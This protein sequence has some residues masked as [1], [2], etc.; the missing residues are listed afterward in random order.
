[1]LSPTCDSVIFIVPSFGYP[2]WTNIS[3]GQ[4][5][6]GANGELNGPVFPI[7]YIHT[8]TWTSGKQS[9]EV[10]SV[11]IFHDFHVH[12]IHFPLWYA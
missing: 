1:M 4:N 11:H 2:I 7:V 6:T 8:E 5:D 9:E 10:K 12:E 3:T